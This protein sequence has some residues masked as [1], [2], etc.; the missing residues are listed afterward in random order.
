MELDDT[1]KNQKIDSWKIGTPRCFECGSTNMLKKN[2]AL[3]ICIDC[4]KRT[5]I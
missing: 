2:N 1:L 3:F 5:L 4:G